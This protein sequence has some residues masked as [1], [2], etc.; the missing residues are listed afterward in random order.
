[1]IKLKSLIFESKILE[2]ICST[3][4]GTLS[5]VVAKNVFSLSFTFNSKNF[6]LTASWRVNSKSNGLKQDSVNQVIQQWKYVGTSLSVRLVTH[7]DFLE[8]YDT[9]FIL[10]FDKTIKFHLYDHPHNN[11]LHF[12]SLKFSMF[13]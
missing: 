5:Q 1:M 6:C 8:C 3:R 7:G 10:T 2:I 9:K 4:T 12:M 13:L 11:Y